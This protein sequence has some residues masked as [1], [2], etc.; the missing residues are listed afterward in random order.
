MA[1]TP[2]RRDARSGRKQIRP[3]ARPGPRRAA[4]RPDTTEYRAGTG[5]GEGGTQYSLLR[6][7]R[8]TKAHP[9]KKPSSLTSCTMSYEGS[10]N[11]CRLLRGRRHHVACLRILA[12]YR[13]RGSCREETELPREGYPKGGRNR[14][15][16]RSFHFHMRL[17]LRI[18]LT[19]FQQLR[20][21]VALLILISSFMG[22]FKFRALQPAGERLTGIRRPC[23]L[24][25]PR[26]PHPAHSVVDRR[27]VPRCRETQ[28]HVSWKPRNS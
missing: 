15:P 8:P 1:A 11:G 12:V 5:H 22:T 4:A 23:M 25:P 27:T 2:R 17:G 18:S 9:R 14:Q 10:R 20:G 3:S 6:C 24:R 26:P 19:F 16:G 28:S 7:F 13:V 21:L